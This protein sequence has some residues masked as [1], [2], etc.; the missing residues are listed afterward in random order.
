MLLI[1]KA[2]GGKPC[3]FSKL[4]V[5]GTHL[6]GADPQDMG[7]SLWGL[8]PFLLR[9]DLHACDIHPTDVSPCQG[10][11]THLSL[12]YPSQCD[13]FF[14]FSCETVVLLVF[15]SFVCLGRFQFELHY[16][17]IL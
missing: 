11:Q 17:I 15:R 14:I 2:L 6:P 4:H 3:S 7:F 8:I 16:M 9:E 10:L 12:S 5:M 1:F 13:F